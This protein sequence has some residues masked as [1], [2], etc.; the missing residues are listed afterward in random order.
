MNGPSL[1]P[2]FSGH[3][4]G[5]RR[6]LS[7]NYDPP[8]LLP[9]LLACDPGSAPHE[10]P[11]PEPVSLATEH[12]EGP[13][14]GAERSPPSP[15][16]PAPVKTDR[17]YQLAPVT[18]P[19]GPQDGFTFWG[20]SPDGRHYAYELFY[21]G[22][23][24]VDCDMRGELIVVDAHK[25]AYAPD[26]RLVFAYP[27]PE[28]P[29]IGPSPTDQAEIGRGSHL[30]RFNIQPLVSGIFNTNRST[31]WLV[32]PA[33]VGHFRLTLAQT[34]GS[35]LSAGYRLE[36]HEVGHAGMPKVIEDGER[37]RELVLGYAVHGVF[38]SPDRS[39]IAVVIEKSTQE[40]E[41]I[42]RSY[43]TNGAALF[44]PLEVIE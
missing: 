44:A 18:G 20:W 21:P 25:D 2:M 8:M 40:F 30:Q 27:S 6:Q 39:H 31:D 1:E 26:G 14:H 16:A 3:L 29:C 23:G 22:S 17:P 13:P 11:T 32:E 9:L 10:P 37:Q 43:M 38:L 5:V 19:E 7:V 41:A 36:L 15:P 28:G 34:G 33:D 4:S 24:A 12:Q 35:N 42:G